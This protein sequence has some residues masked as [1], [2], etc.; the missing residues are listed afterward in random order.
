MRPR[1][2]PCTAPCRPP[3]PRCR[4]AWR[5]SP[6]SLGSACCPSR[7][8]GLRWPRASSW[9]GSPAIPRKCR[10]LLGEN[11]ISLLKVSIVLEGAQTVIY[12]FEWGRMR[13]EVQRV[14][15]HPFDTGRLPS[16]F[17]VERWGGECS[18]YE[19][20]W[21]VLYLRR[22]AMIVHSPVHKREGISLKVQ[23][24]CGSSGVILFFPNTFYRKYC[25]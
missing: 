8:C 18:L 17:S 15:E 9:A 13:S 5:T 23:V 14:M 16:C 2:D 11:G 6:W 4:R 22:S 12:L 20:R 21:K 10:T 24:F 7:P 25:F 1:S 3:P 19:W